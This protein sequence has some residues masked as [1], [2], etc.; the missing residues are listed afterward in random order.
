MNTRFRTFIIA[1]VAVAFVAV[2]P[3]AY[4]VCPDYIMTCHDANKNKRTTTCTTYRAADGSIVTK[5][6]S[7]Y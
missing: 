5:C 4:V 3:N 7:N 2:S 6:T 1:A